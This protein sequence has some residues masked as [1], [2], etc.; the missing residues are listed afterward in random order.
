MNIF[1]WVITIL[2]ALAF[3]AAGAMKLS[4]SKEK[5]AAQ[6]KWAKDFDQN[7]IRGICLLEFLGAIGLVLPRLTHILPWLSS[8]AAVGLI[9]AMIGA[10]MVHVRRKESIVPNLV[11]GVLAATTLYGTIV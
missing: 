9:M 5:L 2:V 1:F 10:A 4:Q 11:L 6:M 7:T 3:L 8:V